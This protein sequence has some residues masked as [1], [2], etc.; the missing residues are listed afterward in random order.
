MRIL[1]FDIEDWFHL[2][3]FNKTKKVSSWAK[4]ESRIHNNIEIIF[5]ILQKNNCKAT[6]FVLGWI[7]EKY[8]EIVKKI[9][10]K[11][12]EIGSHANHHQLVYEQNRK[13]F[14]DD[15]N[16]SIKIL[17]DNTGKAIRYFRAPG[18]SITKDSLW[19]LEE[20]NKLKIQ[21]DCS[22]FPASRSHGGLPILNYSEPCIINYRNFN[23]KEL[24]INTQSFFLKKIIFSGGGYFRLLPYTLIKY[25]TKKNNYIMSYFHPRDFDPNQPV[26]KGLGV[27]RKFK[28]Y[29]GLS[30]SE[31]KL[32]KWLDD[33]KFIDINEASKIINWSKVKKVYL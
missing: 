18:F 12:Y 25:F 17:E 30:K 3:D 8:P 19:A 2:L 13:I 28:S 1:T 22:I 15:I 16:E 10:D 23:I 9:S 27:A 21:I 20:L 4:F 5:D 31:Y 24:P 14:K 6:F 32:N 29:V 7:A 33:Y 11:G 26:L